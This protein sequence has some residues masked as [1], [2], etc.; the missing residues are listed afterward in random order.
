[1]SFKPGQMTYPTS[2]PLGP[3]TSRILRDPRFIPK[4]GAR[5]SEINE[6]ISWRVNQADGGVGIFNDLKA[7]GFS[8]AAAKEAI[9]KWARR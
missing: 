6:W 4:P 3:F 2:E 9:W 8:T 7:A 5:Q 1:M